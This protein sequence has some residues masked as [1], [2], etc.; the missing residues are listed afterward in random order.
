MSVSQRAEDILPQTNVRD[1]PSADACRVSTSVAEI[2]SLMGEPSA[3]M[4]ERLAHM[5][6]QGDDTHLGTMPLY[7]GHLSITAVIPHNGDGAR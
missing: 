4:V 5:S 3:A 1:D 6:P 7:L 2:E